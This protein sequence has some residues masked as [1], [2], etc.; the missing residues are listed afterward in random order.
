[1]RNYEKQIIKNGEKRQ[2]KYLRKFEAGHEK[3][4]IY[5]IYNFCFENY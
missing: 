4:K 2:L 5:F 3:R 1:M